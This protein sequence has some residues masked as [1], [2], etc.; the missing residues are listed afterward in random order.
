MTRALPILFALL[1]S[2]CGIKGGL[3]TP[4]PLFGGQGGGT[5]GEGAAET[6]VLEEPPLGGVGA[7]EG[8]LDDDLTPEPFY[9]P[10]FE[11]ELQG[12]DE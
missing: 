4:P 9:G 12:R 3:A 11:D 7:P 1:L 10:E 8:E 2:G 5:S 6:P